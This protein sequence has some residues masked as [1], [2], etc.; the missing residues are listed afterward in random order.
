MRSSFVCFLVLIFLSAVAWA[1]PDK[2]EPDNTWQGASVILLNC[3]TP[4]LNYEW[5]QR[6]T[7]YEPNDVDWVKFYAVKDEM[8]TVSV[9]DLS[10]K[11]DAV[12]EIYESDGETPAR[13]PVNYHRRGEDEDATFTCE[14]EGIYYAKISQ[15]DTNIKGCYAEYGENTD[16][17]LMLTI[18]IG[19]GYG[20]L[21][22]Y[23][24][25]TDAE[26]VI[27]T[28]GE[29]GSLT[30]KEDGYYRSPHTSGEW[31]LK[32]SAKEYADH[33]QDISVKK[34]P[35]KTRIDIA[36]KTLF[37]EY[38]INS[39]LQIKAIIHTE[40][41]GPIEAV[42]QKGGQG[43]TAGRH[44]V[45]WGYFYADP[46]DVSW[47]SPENPDLFVKIWFDASGRVDVNFFHVSVPDIEVFAEYKGRALEGT[48]TLSR[49]YVRLYYD[50]DGKDGKEESYE[51]G[52]PPAGYSPSGNPPAYP[53]INDLDI[54]AVIK[55]DDGP[56]NAAWRKGGSSPAGGHEVLWGYFYADPEDVSW[57]SR[58]NPDL[59]V[60]V[61]FD[62]DGRIDVNF[63][64][65]SV[66]DIEVYSDFPNDGVYDRKGTTTLNNRYVRQEYRR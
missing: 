56:I 44:E 16:Y 66:P 55:T 62:A 46:E 41:K 26:A 50:Q 14:A 45:V 21:E 3:Q 63:F 32:V 49:R 38:A 5:Y 13:D 35:E 33:Q 17:T 19:T 22:G 58:E 60:K 61:W 59:F 53:T 25:P 27:T 40:D 20:F 9:Q 36:L 43:Q 42:W 8:Y 24:T 23:V 28:T 6:H 7:F 52:N 31:T 10:P 47:G 54:G 2:Y 29:A 34:P 57:G 30:L 65:V 51:N 11:C 37:G 18:P 48:T 15:C 1:G 39:D 4:N 12:I 64:H